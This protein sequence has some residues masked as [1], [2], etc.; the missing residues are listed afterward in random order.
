MTT[1][2]RRRT[3]HAAK[4]PL[5]T[6][7][8]EESLRR[9]FQLWSTWASRLECALSPARFGYSDVR[10]SLTVSAKGTIHDEPGLS[11]TGLMESKTP[12]PTARFSSVYSSCSRRFGERRGGRLPQQSTSSVQIVPPQPRI[13]RIPRF[14]R[15]EKILKFAKHCIDISRWFL[16]NDRASTA[17]NGSENV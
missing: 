11:P 9:P 7:C 2:F 1:N 3:Y 16:V 12:A 15:P 14:R 8:T 6:H 17:K 10:G 5:F 4:P 13:E